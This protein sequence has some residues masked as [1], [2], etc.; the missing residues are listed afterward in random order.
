MLNYAF[1]PSGGVRLVISIDG[2]G[3]DTVCQLAADF[4]WKHGEKEVILHPANMGLRKHILS[5]GDLTKKYGE[6]I[7]LEDD[8]GVSRY[9]YE[10]VLCSL[11]QF[12]D[13]KVVAGISLY[14]HAINVNCGARFEPVS[15]GV[16]YFYMQFPQSWGQ[17]WTCQQWES[18]RAW[19]DIDANHTKDL[20]IPEYVSRWPEC[21]WL[22]YYL[23][24]MVDES[25]FFVYPNVSYSTNFN[26]TGTNVGRANNT[27]QLPLAECCLP[28]TLDDS[29]ALY[30]DVYFEMTVESLSKLDAPLAQNVD[31]MDL[32]GCRDLTR[33]PPEA[34]ILT[35]RECIDVSAT[36]ALR[37]RPRVM[38]LLLKCEGDGISL[39]QVSGVRETNGVLRDFMYDLRWLGGRRMIPV[40]YNLIVQRLLRWW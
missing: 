21:S 19:Y 17:V 24:Y 1:Y 37:L 10:Y 26:D 33:Y 29:Q 28:M 7:M 8:I 40:I 5:C 14:K 12:S 3:S 11:R 16:D 32:F 38:N 34:S 4:E 15:N 27:Y 22:K 13:S 31:V 30:Y 35:V 39:G 9:F 36:Y 23:K 20:D 25:L 18:F 6:I 2:G